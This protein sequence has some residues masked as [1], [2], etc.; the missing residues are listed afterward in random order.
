MEQPLVSNSEEVFA[1][2]NQLAGYMVSVKCDPEYFDP[3]VK[4]AAEDWLK[5]EIAELTEEYFRLKKEAATGHGD[6]SFN[7]LENINALS[8][9]AT[10][11][12]DKEVQAYA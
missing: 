3:E 7:A 6:Y 4:P 8:I 12:D 2:I 10:E 5:G 9:P 11:Q 1:R